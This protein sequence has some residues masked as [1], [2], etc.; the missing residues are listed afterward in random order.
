[1]NSMNAALFFAGCYEF[2]CVELLL[3]SCPNFAAFNT[4]TFF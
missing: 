1:M 4:F 3:A 2:D